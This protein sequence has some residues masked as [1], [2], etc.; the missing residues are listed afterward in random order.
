VSEQQSPTPAEM[1]ERYFGPAIFAPWAAVLLEHAAPQI[2][3]RVLDVACGTGIVT[4][5]VAPVLGPRG[6]VVGIDISPQMLE[7][8]RGLP[9]PSGAAIEWRQGDAAALPL[10]DSA[11]DLVLCQ[12]GLQFVP[13]RAAALEEMRRVLADDG[14]VA[15]SIWQGLEH[16]PVYRPLFEAEARHLGVPLDEVASPFSLGDADE[17][18][19]LLNDAG[20]GRVDITPKSMTVRFPSPDR[21]V[22]LTLLAGAAVIPALAEE[23]SRAAL[24]EAIAPEIEDITRRYRDGDTLAFPMPNHI[25]VARD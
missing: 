3:E 14:R 20:F 24:V 7:V 4:R 13:D 5:Q 16:H 1:Y 8:A 6:S 19:A 12:Q 21:F 2:G 18:R 25:A 23:A 15:L 17:L 9:A 22:Q 10:P 11:F